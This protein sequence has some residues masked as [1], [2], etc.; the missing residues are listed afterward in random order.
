MM[1]L[2]TA[3][4]GHNP[5]NGALSA[6]G[7]A[8]SYGDLSDA[9][10]QRVRLIHLSR[11]S[12]LAL[13]MDNGV[14]WVL[15]D[16]AALKAGVPLVPVPPFFT[17]AQ[18]RHALSA[19]GCTGMI[20]GDDIIPLQNTPVH[21]PPGTAKVTF[22][23]GTTGT[24]KGVCLSAA[25]MMSVAESIVQVLGRGMAGR[26]L[27][28][29]PLP[30]LLENVAGVYATLMAGGTVCLCPLSTFGA[31]YAR[32][33]EVMA[34]QA[35]SS[36]ILVPEIL[37][38]LMTQ[39]MPKAVRDNLKFVAV[40]GS[41]VSPDL[42]RTA[43][44]SGLPVYEGYGLSECASVVSLNTPGADRPGT[45][46]RLLPHL[47]ADIVNGEI[48]VHGAGFLGYVGETHSGGVVTGDLGT[49][50][51]DGFLSIT[52]RQKNILIT[53]YGRNISPEW[54]ESELLSQPG[55]GQAVVYGDG[56]P[57]LRAFITPASS[58]AD[59]PGSIRQVNERLP[60]Y[61]RIRH[62]SV[63]PPFSVQNETLTGTGRPRRDHILTLY[64]QEK[65]HD[66]L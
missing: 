13:S 23:S 19:S 12:C 54:V 8:L 10:D 64:A 56:A 58:S 57:A 15:W 3:I 55:I 30:V 4:A 39:N 47:R 21:L 1:P 63:V 45:A 43:R 7:R 61:A 52:G 32:L 35:V 59:I 49:M 60:D 22:T 25:S 20:A 16:L 26:H 48:V 28:V 62:F 44:R 53:S 9:I 24:P 40:G 50:D 6:P 27:S 5:K 11:A 37:R 31:H 46:G 18:I 41:K 17:P 33:A 36:V 2:F 34:D 29:L 14:D 66:V 38:I 65:T 51:E 42:I